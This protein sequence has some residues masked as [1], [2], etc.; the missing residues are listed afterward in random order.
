[1]NYILPSENL[2]VGEWSIE[3][4]HLFPDAVCSRIENLVSGY[5]SKL[6]S[7]EDFGD[8]E[9]LYRDKNDNRLWEKYYP[10]SELH[11]GGPPSLRVISEGEARRKYK[12]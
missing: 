10:K 7:S 6:S 4:G 11:G 8:W 1:M 3:K 12:F 9:I 5:L 2:I